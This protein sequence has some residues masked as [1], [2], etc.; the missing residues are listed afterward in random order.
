[1]PSLSDIIPR[2]TDTETV[3]AIYA[4]YKKRGDA[5]PIRGYLGASIIGHPCERYLWFS[6]RACCKGDF[7]GRMYRLFETGDLA[8]DRFAD[9][10]RSI[11]ATVHVTDEHGEQFSV[12]A[13]GGHF[14]GHLDGCAL[15]IP[16]APKA[17][18]VLEFKTHNSKNF[19]KLIKDGVALAFPKHHAQMMIY[20]HYTGMPRALYLAVNKDTDELYSERVRYDTKQ[21]ALLVQRAERIIRAQEPPT[22]ISDRPDFWQ[23]KMC[24]ARDICH[25]SVAP[26]PALIVPALSCKQCCHATPTMGG[27]DGRWVCEK[28]KKAL[29]TSAQENLCEDHLV[30]PGLLPLFSPVDTGKDASGSDFIQFQDDKGNEFRHGREKGAFSSVE[31]TVLPA[32]LLANSMVTRAKDVFDGTAM[33][34]CED[35]LD[36]YPEKDC[37]IL[38]RGNIGGLMEALVIQLGHPFVDDDII[39]RTV[40]ST[41]CVAEYEGGVIAIAYPDTGRA[42]IKRRK[43]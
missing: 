42:E 1:M 20:M 37:E 26:A 9:N 4:Q 36:R 7:S 40:L 21:A 25:G 33:T 43:A 17:W 23:C 41:H 24:N 18:H 34:C 6:F 35:I 8:E 19:K 16:E 22:R 32:P 2:P 14:S 11:G 29:S 12:S 13:F 30:L 31:L 38:W 15:G 5:E 3:R 39:A 10:L 28:H 27:V